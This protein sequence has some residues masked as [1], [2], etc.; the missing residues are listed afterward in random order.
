MSKEVAQHTAEGKPDH[1]PQDISC[2]TL[3]S[4]SIRVSWTSPP[5]ASANGVIKGY[6]VIFGP[7]ASWY[8]KYAIPHI[9]TCIKIRIF[10]YIYNQLIIMYIIV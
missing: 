4:Q 1:A 10:I 7:A 2:T 8:G 5:L 3:T 9:Y 6:K